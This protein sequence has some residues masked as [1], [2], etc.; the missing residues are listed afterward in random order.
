MKIQKVLNKQ[1]LWSKI[2]NFDLDNPE[3]S[4]SFSKRLARENGWS[5]EYSKRVINEYKK[6]LY[7]SVISGKSGKSL[8]PSDEVDQ[9]WHLHMVYTHSYWQDLC[10]DTLGVKFHHGPTKGGKN[11]GEKYATQYQFTL[12]FYKSEL[13]QDA[14][15]DIWPSVEK[16]FA[17]IVY[18]R[19]NMHENFVMNKKNVKQYMTFYILLLTGVFTCGILMSASTTS[20]V[21]WSSTLMLIFGIVLG[22]FLIRGF[23]RY[24]TRDERSSDFSTTYKNNSYKPTSKSSSSTKS[25]SNSSSSSKSSS[26]SNT[27]TNTGG[28]GIAGSFFG[29]SSSSDSSHGC[30]SS[31]GGGDGGSGCGGGGCGGGGCGGCG[32]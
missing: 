17:N 20:D 5:E 30:S 31:D 19:V 23:Y 32:G 1:E 29:C 2:S 28:C 9:A 21:D 16:R 15:T 26:D 7:L 18:R 8:T 11:E 24:A 14:P 12:D 22:I 6:F 3:A 13:G 27:T 25:N 10:R 4:F